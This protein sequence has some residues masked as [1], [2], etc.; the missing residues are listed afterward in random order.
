M[1][2]G[3]NIYLMPAQ[4][5][6]PPKVIHLLRQTGENRDNYPDP[7]TLGLHEDS[8]PGLGVCRLDDHYTTQEVTVMISHPV[9]LM[10]RTLLCQLDTAQLT[11]K[12]TYHHHTGIIA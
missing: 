5:Q 7:D 1:L 10:T 9:C 4:Q 8:C 6:S 3:K 12:H 2:I 11:K